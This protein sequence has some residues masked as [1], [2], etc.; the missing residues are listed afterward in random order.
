MITRDELRSNRL[1]SEFDD[2]ELDMVRLVAEEINFED[3]DLILVEG[4][5][6]KRLYMIV[7]GKCSVT[8]QISGTGTEEIKLLE[9]NEFFG[10]MSLI[11]AAPISASVYARGKCRLLWI[12]RKAFDRLIDEDMPIANKLLKAIIQAFCERVRDTMEKM[13]SY[14]KMS[15]F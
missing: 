8:T 15:K 9:A 11:E 12:D 7:M 14:Y 13:Q 3:G 10:E 6:G 5:P 1:F 4:E 2:H